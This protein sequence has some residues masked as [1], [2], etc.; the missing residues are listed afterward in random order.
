MRNWWWALLLTFSVSAWASDSSKVPGLWVMTDDDPRY[1]VS[2]TEEETGN[3][4]RLYGQVVEVLE[5]AAS[6][7]RRCRGD[8][9]GMPILGMDLLTDVFHQGSVWGGGAMLDPIT[10]REWDVRFIISL[11]LQALTVELTNPTLSSTIVQKWRRVS[12]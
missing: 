7:C 3:G 10:G 12:D 9:L 6:E 1:V 5:G 4:V 8:R 11:D 2:L